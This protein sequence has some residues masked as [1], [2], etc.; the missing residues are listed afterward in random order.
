MIVYSNMIDT[1]ILPLP[2][3]EFEVLNELKST[4]PRCDNNCLYHTRFLFEM[5]N[6]S[7]EQQKEIINKL[8][9][10]L[11]RVVYSG[12]KSLH[13]IIEF[14]LDDEDYCRE[15]YISI[16]NY[17]NETYFEGKCD[18]QCKN[19]S[20]LTRRPDAIRQ[21]TGKTQEKLHNNPNCKIRVDSKMRR[22]VRSKWNEIALLNAFR[23]TKNFNVNASHNGM[24]INYTPVKHY[25]ETPYLKMKGNGDSSSS[26]FK[27][28]LCCMKYGDKSSLDSILNK[29]HNEH[30]SD[31]EIEHKIEDARKKL[32]R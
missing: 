31:T 10:V 2:S 6:D 1:S 7:L 22:Y 28:I 25:L 23:P 3:Y 12:S 18:S 27:A 32:G 8:T 20:R 13:C 19:P 14:S 30:W 21:D 24:C 29:A 4:K 11:R 15:N 5:D 9:H 17:L 26:L 16:W